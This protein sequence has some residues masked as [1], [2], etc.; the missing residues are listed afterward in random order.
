MDFG[1]YPK[2]PLN[3]RPKKP[4]AAS[5]AH[6]IFSTCPP[7]QH[8]YGQFRF[9]SSYLFYVMQSSLPKKVKKKGRKER[10]LS[11][12]QPKR[13]RIL[14]K[15]KYMQRWF[16]RN[17]WLRPITVFNLAAII[18]QKVFRGFR[19]RKLKKKILTASKTQIGSKKKNSKGRQLDKYLEFVELCK[20]KKIKKKVCIHILTSTQS[21]NFWNI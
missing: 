3:P 8:L 15:S 14:K 19:V 11:R 16:V 2:N 20:S 21:I 7:V 4:T 18:V 9:Y 6:F 17:P 12:Q 13:L 1:G 5:P 10:H